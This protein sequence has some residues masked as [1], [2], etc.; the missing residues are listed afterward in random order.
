MEEMSTPKRVTERE[1]GGEDASLSTNTPARCWNTGG[2]ELVQHF[3]LDEF[4][5]RR[6]WEVERTKVWDS[7][8]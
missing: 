3:G 2:H 6:S 1:A 8:W 5:S 4:L 7:M